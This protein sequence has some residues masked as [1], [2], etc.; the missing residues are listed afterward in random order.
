MW[1]SAVLPVVRLHVQGCKCKIKR[2]E[3]WPSGAAE[4]VTSIYCSCRFRLSAGTRIERLKS[5]GAA[6]NTHGYV[7]QQHITVQKAA[8]RQTRRR[9]VFTIFADKN[10]AVVE[11]GVIEGAHGVSSF[12][13]RAKLNNAAAFA[14][15]VLAGE[16]VGTSHV[17]GAAEVILES[18]PRRL[19]AYSLQ[20]P[21][22]PPPTPPIC[23]APPPTCCLISLAKPPPGTPRPLGTRS[24]LP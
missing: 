18:L 15:A 8:R 23:G 21:P 17:A 1:S 24:P 16:N 9:L 5:G 12:L 2:A 20:P 10:L 4:S 22:P 14:S 13:G 19:L 6:Y 7:Q 11:H 3:R